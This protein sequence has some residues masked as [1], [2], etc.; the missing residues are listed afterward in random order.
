VA[1]ALDALPP[2]P[3]SEHA[4]QRMQTKS[5]LDRLASEG[6]MLAKT[7]TLAACCENFRCFVLQAR[8]WEC[9]KLQKTKTL[10]LVLGRLT[11]LSEYCRASELRPE[12]QL[13]RLHGNREKVS[14]EE[15]PGKEERQENLRS[16]RVLARLRADP[17]QDAGRKRQL[18]AEATPDRRGEEGRS[19]GRCCLKAERATQVAMRHAQTGSRAPNA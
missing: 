15:N 8:Q 1:L 18:R 2:Q 16:E 17:R 19:E 12:I 14:Y 4:V 7:P 9:R 5:G 13:L 6:F 10:R 11:R 3:A